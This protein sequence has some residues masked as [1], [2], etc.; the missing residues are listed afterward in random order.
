[1]NANPT[2]EQDMA[3]T[4]PVVWF[5]VVGQDADKA[6]SFYGELLGWRFQVDPASGYGVVEGAGEE[7]GVAGGIGPAAPG[8]PSR[9]T[10]YTQV[11]DLDATIAKAQALGSTVLM[12][13]TKLPETTIAVVSDPEG[14]PVGICA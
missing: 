7:G 12:P 2:E 3:K 6:R 10:F 14:L 5:E 1:M 8:Q 11:D 9:V 4:N 13:P